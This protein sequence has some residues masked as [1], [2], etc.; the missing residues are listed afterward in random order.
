MLKIFTQLLKY[1]SK[2]AYLCISGRLRGSK[3]KK[4]KK[5][6]YIFIVLEC[7]EIRKYNEEILPLEFN[8]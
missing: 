5:L 3:I 4:K 6:K 8:F 7:L 1:T 2:I